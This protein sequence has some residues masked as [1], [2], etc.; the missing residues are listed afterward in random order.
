M[1]RSLDYHIKAAVTGIFNPHKPGSLSYFI[2]ETEHSKE[3]E[4]KYNE[5]TRSR[6]LQK[7]LIVRD[8]QD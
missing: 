5:V 6:K 8:S 4:V 1:I 3:R 2:W 7:R